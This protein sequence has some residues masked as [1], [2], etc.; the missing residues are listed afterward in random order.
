MYLCVVVGKILFINIIIS[1][2]YVSIL[3]C[4]VYECD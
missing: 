1:M 4:N 3:I 2:G